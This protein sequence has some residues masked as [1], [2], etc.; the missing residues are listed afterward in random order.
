MFQIKAKRLGLLDWS[1]D[2]GCLGKGEDVTLG[3]AGCLFL[4]QVIPEERVSDTLE[5]RRWKE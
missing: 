4:L 5:C 2:L 1:L 3:E